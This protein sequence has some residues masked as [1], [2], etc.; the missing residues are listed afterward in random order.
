MRNAACK[1]CGKP[2]VWATSRDG[3]KIPLDPR[4]PV[5]RVTVVEDIVWCD[6]VTDVM[7]SHFT[8]CKLASQFSGAGARKGRGAA[9][10]P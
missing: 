2:I 4:P 3:K 5:Y 10:A 1:G 9:G 8:T 7:V 6:R